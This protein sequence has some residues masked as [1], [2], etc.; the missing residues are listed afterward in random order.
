MISSDLIIISGLITAFLCAVVVI[1]WRVIGKV[2]FVS[3]HWTMFVAMSIGALVM[4]WFHFDIKR[5]IARGGSPLLLVPLS[6]FIFEFVLV[7]T[8]LIA[9]GAIFYYTVNVR[10]E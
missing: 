7:S 1:L 2:E 3:V 6:R 5:I 9:L 8:A 4:G 10:N